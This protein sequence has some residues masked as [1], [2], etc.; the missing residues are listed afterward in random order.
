VTRR[1][2]EKC[3]I[4]VVGCLRRYFV[5]ACLMERNFVG[6]FIVEGCSVEGWYEEG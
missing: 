5:E 6:S 4:S 3:L 2:V 1:F